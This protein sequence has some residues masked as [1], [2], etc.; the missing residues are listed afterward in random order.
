LPE[1]LVASCWPLFP[2]LA[3]TEQA[4]HGED[5]ISFVG[6]TVSRLRGRSALQD[7]PC[8]GRAPPTGRLQLSQERYQV[9]LLLRRELQSL[10]EVEELDG[11]LQRQTA[12]VVQ[13]G[14]AILDAPQ[15]E[16]LDRPVPCFMLEEALDVEV[17]HL[18]IEVEGRR[19]AGG[20][21]RF[22]EE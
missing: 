12:A 21:L 9:L 7:V 16:G 3:S 22:A 6:T 2:G 1:T 18:V 5:G 19:M 13:V 8:P 20:A 14:R 11:V 10:D 4:E 17:M 15:G